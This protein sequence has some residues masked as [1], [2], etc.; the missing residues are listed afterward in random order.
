MRIRK[1]IGIQGRRVTLRDS[2]SSVGRPRMRM[3]STA[4]PEVI[5]S[6]RSFAGNYR[7]GIKTQ[8]ATT[9]AF[10]RDVQ[11]ERPK[12]K[13]SPPR[14]AHEWVSRHP[15]KVMGYLGKWI[16]I[17]H[18]GIQSSGKTMDDV[19]RKAANKGIDNPLVFKVS[20]PS[21]PRA[22]SVRAG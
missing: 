11:V 9:I 16:A 22:V 21:G 17:T 7:M 5:F 13:L 6:G 20:K 18:K 14:T 1:P 19:Y 12:H 15:Q 4:M 3:A 10:E 8:G 2:V